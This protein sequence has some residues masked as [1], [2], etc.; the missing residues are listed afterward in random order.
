MRR[1]LSLLL[2]AALVSPLLAVGFAAVWVAPAQADDT[3]TA[4]STWQDSG[5]AESSGF[6]GLRTT[7][8]FDWRY[9]KTGTSEADA[10]LTVQ[11]RNGRC[12]GYSQSVFAEAGNNFTIAG[13]GADVAASGCFGGTYGVTGAGD[14]SWVYDRSTFSGDLQFTSKTCAVTEFGMEITHTRPFLPDSHA[15][16]DWPVESGPDVPIRRGRWE[17]PLYGQ[18]ADRGFGVPR[19]LYLFVGRLHLLSDFGHVGGCSW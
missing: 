4:Y 17:L 14:G 11:V 19:D 1:W 3:L 6:V 15:K 12:V 16:L 9:V 7:C 13:T 18:S 8:W 5:D 2:A 10:V